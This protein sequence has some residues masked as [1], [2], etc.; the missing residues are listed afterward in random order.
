MYVC[1]FV[2]MLVC[3]FVS[4][5]LVKSLNINQAFVSEHVIY[6][7]YFVIDPIRTRLFV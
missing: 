6:D 2:C 7:P 3:V 1:M 4:F 5:N